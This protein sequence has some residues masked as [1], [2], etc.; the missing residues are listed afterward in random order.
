MKSSTKNSTSSGKGISILKN[1]LDNSV[2][3]KNADVDFL[4]SLN[5]QVKN[6]HDL[7]PRQLEVLQK[8]YKRYKANQVKVIFQ[9]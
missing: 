6:K 4:K 2:W 9:G 5:E 7:S 3:L 8:I 1:M